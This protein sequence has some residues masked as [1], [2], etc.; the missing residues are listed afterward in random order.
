MPNDSGCE[1]CQSLRSSD[2]VVEPAYTPIIKGV[3]LESGIV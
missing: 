1:R 3:L 2:L